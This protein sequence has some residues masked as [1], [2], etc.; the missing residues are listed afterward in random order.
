M[1]KRYVASKR[2]TI[3]VDFDDYLY[4]LAKERRAGAEQRARRGAGLTPCSRLMARRVLVRRLLPH[5]ASR[6]LTKAANREAILV[7]LRCACSQT[8]AHG[9]ASVR[10]IVREIE[11]VPSKGYT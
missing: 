11:D 3:Q 8:S 5:C 1:R 10:D 9:A 7:A 6:E 4:A 2:H